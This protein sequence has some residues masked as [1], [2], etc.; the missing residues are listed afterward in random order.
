VIP[1]SELRIG[2][3]VAVP[4]GMGYANLIFK[5]VSIEAVRDSL[6]YN[7]GIVSL[8][9][10]ER[11]NSRNLELNPIPLSE[12]RHK[13]LGGDFVFGEDFR[14]V[15]VG[16]GLYIERGEILQPLKHIHY[17]HQRQNLQFALSGK[18]PTTTI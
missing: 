13:R 1:E 9:G 11:T 7:I 4:V 2:N 17:A 10:K 18:E 15:W 3:I 6:A 14:C 5:V 16:N 12:Q 8:D